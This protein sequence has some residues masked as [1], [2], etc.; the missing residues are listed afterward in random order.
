MK[1]F[2]IKY[3]DNPDGVRISSAASLFIKKDGVF[4]KD[5]AKDGIFHVFDDW[6]LSPVQRASALV[7]ILTLREKAALLFVN[8]WRMGCE[9]KDKS[10]V[11]ES[12]YLD[13]EIIEKGTSIFASEKTYGT[14]FSM[15]DLHLRNFILRANPK[16][17]DLVSWTN[18]LQAISESDRVIIPSLVISNSRNE[19]GESIFGMNES[20]GVFT[21]WPGTLGIA[22]AIKGTG[23]FTI[24]DDFGACIRSEWDAVGLKKGYMYMADAATDPRWQRIYGTF[25][26]DSH[27]IGD[28]FK[29]LIPA[30]QGSCEGVVSSGVSMTVKHFPG[31]G[32]R[33]NGF[34]PHY[35]EGQ[36]NVYASEDSLLKYHLPAFV[37]AIS[38]NPASIMP[39]YAK[40]AKA[41]SASQHDYTGKEI[42]WECVG[43]AYNR[44]FIQDLLKGQLGFKGYINS[45]SGITR[46]MAWGVEN[47]EACERVAL[48]INTGVDLISGIFEIDSVIEAVKRGKEGYYRT[49]PLPSPYTEEQITLREESIDRAILK[50]LAERFALGLFD[51]PFRSPDKAEKAFASTYYQNCAQR[52]HEKSVVLLKNHASLLPLSLEGKRVYVRSFR[53]TREEAEKASEQFLSLCANEGMCIESDPSA[54]DYAIFEISP[55][56]GHYFKATE[57][58]LEIDICE[59]KR[60]GNTAEGKPSEGTHLETTLADVKEIARIAELVHAHKGKVIAMVNITMPWILQNV[61][62]YVDS[63]L[64]GFDTYSSAFIHVMEGKAPALGRLPLTLPSS[65]CV[66]AVDA[67]GVSISPNDVP[68]YDKD[69]YLPEGMHY[70]YQD[71]DGNAYTYGFGLTFPL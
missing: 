16:P 13:E 2:T 52:V 18:A 58:F 63:L 1:T 60:V 40:P 3:H 53:Q 14:T 55:H 45:D 41:K 23:D 12:G 68:G 11:D 47:L 39:Y 10:L 67:Q 31:G 21:A 66:I 30:I 28:V 25:G 19:N 6:H 5:I 20:I 34:D 37:D 48:A 71:A 26:E 62:P 59:D 44:Y 42:S 35:K 4:Y 29:R 61:E 15:L 57:G 50:T 51:D 36:W 54:S 69:A 8:S 9:Q 46:H 70:A 22:A 7:K 33:E 17:R 38:M 27:F 49:H 32:A 65:D 24:L 43:F 56:S 64:V